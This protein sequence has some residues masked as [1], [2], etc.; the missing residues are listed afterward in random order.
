MVPNS[1]F[2][3][4]RNSCASE[5]GT[6]TSTVFFFTHDGAESTTLY[7]LKNHHTYLDTA[8]SFFSFITLYR[9]HTCYAYTRWRR[10]GEQAGE[11][12]AHSN[13]MKIG[14]QKT[15]QKILRKLPSRL[16]FVHVPFSATQHPCDSRI[17]HTLIKS[18]TSPFKGLSA[19]LLSLA[20]PP[21][22]GATPGPTT[23]IESPQQVL[24]NP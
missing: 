14:H 12:A 4:V 24:S 22:T 17:Y 3:V 21:T 8:F 13:Q 6:S 19:S 15:K 20:R 2:N 10:M 7:L 11:Q 18:P 5:R 9:T 23:T 1:M 16:S